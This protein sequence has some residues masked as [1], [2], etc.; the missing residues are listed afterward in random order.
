MSRFRSLANPFNPSNALTKAAVIWATMQAMMDSR[1]CDCTAG[2][3]TPA[4][5]WACFSALHLLTRRPMTPHR[6]LH[7]NDLDP[8][9][10]ES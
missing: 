5:T 6:L 3:A 8:E 2:A 10:R 4:A 7:S 1:S 9:R